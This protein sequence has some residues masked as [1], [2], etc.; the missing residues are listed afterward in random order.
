ME[1]II[2][3]GLKKLKYT[4]IYIYVRVRVYVYY[5]SIGTELRNACINKKLYILVAQIY[6]SHVFQ[7]VKFYH[8][9]TRRHT[10][11]LAA[12]YLHFPL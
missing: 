8:T 6:F 11:A 5:L 10:L 2:V 1:Y 3:D 4:Y 9:K 12:H 7:L